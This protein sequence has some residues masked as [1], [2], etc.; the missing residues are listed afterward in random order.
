MAKP[1]SKPSNAPKKKTNRDKV[2]DEIIKIKRTNSG[3]SKLPIILAIVG[4]VLL[5]AVGGLI[6]FLSGDDNKQGVVTPGGGGTGGGGRRTTPPDSGATDTPEPPANTEANQKIRDLLAKLDNET[7]RAGAARELSDRLKNA[8]EPQIK[9]MIPALGQK[10]KAGNQAARE[11]LREASRNNEHPLAQNLA[12][13]ELGRLGENASASTAALIDPSNLLPVN[14]QALLTLDVR[15]LLTSSYER[16]LFTFGAYRLEDFSSRLGIP[17][18][19]VDKFAI[20]ANKEHANVLAIVR[21]SDSLDWDEVK[22]KLHIDGQEYKTSKGRA[23]FLGKVD[24]LTEFLAEPMPAVLGLKNKAA[25]WKMNDQTLVY[26]DEETVKELIDN[27]PAAPVEEKPAVAANPTAPAT[28][29]QPT[30]PLVGRSQGGGGAST[31]LLP[32]PPPAEETP[33]PDQGGDANSGGAGIVLPGG[34]PSGPNAGSRR[35]DTGPKTYKRIDARLRQVIEAAQAK[36]DTLAIFADSSIPGRMGKR[37]SPAASMFVLRNLPEGQIEQ[38]DMLAIALPPLHA[39]N[40]DPTLRAA[41]LCRDRRDSEQV[42]GEVEKA[43]VV[44]KE[45]LKELFGF[46]FKVGAEARQTTRRTGGANRGGGIG[47]PTIGDGSSGGSIGGPGGT[48]GGMIGGPGGTGGGDEPPPQ[49]GGGGNANRPPPNTGDSGAALTRPSGPPPGSLAGQDNQAPAI[50]ERVVEEGLHGRVTVNRA[51]EIVLVLITVFN[52]KDDFF[53]G[54]I[55][56]IMVKLRGET[57]IGSGKVRVGD[58]AK[59]IEFYR[60]S[61]SAAGDSNLAP[62]A[63][64]RR[65]ANPSRGPRPYPPS[66]CVSWM[67]ALLNYLPGDRYQN[68]ASEVDPT[69]SWRDARNV[70]VGRIL[71]TPFLNPS[72]E[73]PKTHVRMR[74][75]DLPLA[76]TDFVGMAGVGPDA[77]YYDKNDRR[78]GVF[79][80]NRQ[81]RLED[82]KD[83]ASNTIFMIQS[84]SSV[85][86]PWI[87]G[88]GST[89]RGT[90]ETGDRDVGAPG[91]FTSPN[92]GGKP[93]V[94]IIMVDGS[95]R[96]LT[97]DVSPSVFKALCT[98]NGSDD[99]GEIDLLAPKAKL[100]VTPFSPA[101]TQPGAAKPATGGTRPRS[102]IRDDD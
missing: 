78:A 63:V 47:P 86:G 102:T 55:G 60:N 53:E 10:A 54:P 92:F 51:D 62:L 26:G 15:R 44:A 30:Q 2:N 88:G 72:R 43:L 79:G 46:N 66:E 28:P 22:T 18:G 74:G 36:Q 83:G 3:A 57:E 89:V 59:G 8:S 14:T 100:E 80:Y 41:L 27:P 58:L 71:I 13:A 84:D 7:D 82:V 70:N 87:A 95:A 20:G 50:E 68:L 94:W 40:N 34:R 6:F 49:G 52:K 45:N 81:T 33:P 35:S 25:I 97:K 93:G 37:K 38:I 29:A 16:G 31:G 11:L 99:S 19:N 17:L 98:I 77:P 42:R 65:A 1:G 9:M 4:V 96:F 73:R 76:V 56:N 69:G 32:T 75:V 12:M 61:L 48:G 64:S 21:T 101:Q 5:V 90:S 67:P 85:T 91:G 23:Y 24:F 39:T